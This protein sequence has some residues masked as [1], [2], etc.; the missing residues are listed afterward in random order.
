MIAFVA[1]V[2]N[3]RVIGYKNDLPW[4][5][6]ADL[7]HFQKVTKHGTVIMGRKTF[8]S[9]NGPLP[10]RTNI[11][12]TGNT[13]WS[14]EGAQV[15]HDIEEIRRLAGEEKLYYVIGGSGVFTELLPDASYMYLTHIDAD[16]PG[17]TYFP[18]WNESEWE[19]AEKEEGPVDEKNKHPHRYVT[20]KRKSFND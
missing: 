20:Y 10:S 15:V 5:L 3:D 19:I 11:V 16:V 18:E 9:M 13:D 6:P 2:A 12:I 7:K 17:D 8:E 4:H 1:A 14:H